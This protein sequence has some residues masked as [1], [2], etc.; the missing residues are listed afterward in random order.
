MLGQPIAAIAQP[1]GE[2][3]EIDRIAQRLTAAGS[4]GNRRLIEN[5]E[6]HA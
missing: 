6:L 1:I 2:A 4:F 5:T 3:G